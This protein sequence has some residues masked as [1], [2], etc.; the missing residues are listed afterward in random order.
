[1]PRV[2]SLE[3]LYGARSWDFVDEKTG[4]KVAG[5]KLIHGTGDRSTRENR[6]GAEVQESTIDPELYRRIER[7]LPCVAEVEYDM[8]QGKK[9]VELRVYDVAVVQ[10]VN[11]EATVLAQA[12]INGAAGR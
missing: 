9:A 2:K 12:A 7:E 6:A 11:V 3:V 4:R 8:V 10:R 5:A 1:M